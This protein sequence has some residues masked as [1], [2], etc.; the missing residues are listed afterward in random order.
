MAKL[1]KREKQ[2]SGYLVRI[3]IF[4]SFAFTLCFASFF[5]IQYDSKGLSMSFASKNIK[6]S[7]DLLRKQYHEILLRSASLQAHYSN[8]SGRSIHL[9]SDLNNAERGTIAIK[10][11]SGQSTVETDMRI[12]EN[13]DIVIGMAQDTDPKNLITFCAS[14]RKY[15]S[16]QQSKVV[17]FINAPVLQRNIDI[18]KKFDVELIEFNPRNLSILGKDYKNLE[19]YHPSSLRWG[20]ILN[21]FHDVHVRNR[22]KKVLLID[23]RDSFF[24]SDPF[25]IIPSN[26][27]SA[28]YGFKGVEYISISQ[29]GWN[30]GWIRDCFPK[31]ILDDIG[32]NNIICSG[33]SIGT[34]DVVYQYLILM[35]D[36]L[37]ARKI[38]E[39]SKIS[40]FPGSERNGVDQGVCNI[41]FLFWFQFKYQFMLSMFLILFCIFK[42]YIENNPW[43]HLT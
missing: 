2:S 29:C 15:S 30:G 6:V 3:S 20:F 28:F 41:L 11:D 8:I 35:D 24:Q 22:Y 31:N 1:R 18:A 23:V 12:N 27:I 43:N 33:V 39:I 17:L 42:F 36:I 7:Q 25:S 19:R 9:P 40:R 10:S 34:I 13:L 26:I 14:F 37:M 32:H 16:I 21:Y 4:L 38:S 5:L